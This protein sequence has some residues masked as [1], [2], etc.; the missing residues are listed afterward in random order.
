[1]TD[2]SRGFTLVETLLALTLIGLLAAMAYP[3]YARHLHKGERQAIQ[4]ALH[5]QL[6]QQEQYRVQHNRYAEFDAGEPG[7]LP[8][9]ADSMH[10]KVRYVLGARVCRS[11]GTSQTATS[12]CIEAYA[13]PA[14]LHTAYPAFAIDSLGRRRCPDAPGVTSCWD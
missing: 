1:M 10:G 12:D 4:T 8:F 11:G 2:I 13:Q 7:D 6:L 5:E 3:S 14:T 9:R